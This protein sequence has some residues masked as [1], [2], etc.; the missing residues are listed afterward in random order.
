MLLVNYRALKFRVINNTTMENKMSIGSMSIRF[1]GTL[2]S[3][4]SLPLTVPLTLFSSF[5]VS[6][7]HHNRFT[8]G[9][10][11]FR[12]ATLN[13]RSNCWACDSVPASLIGTR[14]R[15]ELRIR[16]RWG[17]GA[18]HSTCEDTLSIRLSPP[19]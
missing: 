3:R 16:R 4:S 6:R 10:R 5:L 15:D 17:E 11:M 9:A 13:G 2:V 8:I 19:P 7:V 14:P 18:N 12:R 1:D